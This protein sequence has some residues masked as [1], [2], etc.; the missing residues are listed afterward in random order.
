MSAHMSRNCDKQPLCTHHPPTAAD[1]N[2]RSR[3]NNSSSKSSKKGKQAIAT[4]SFIS[5]AV[6]EEVQAPMHHIN[7]RFLS[8]MSILCWEPV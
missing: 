4:R 6:V 5:K 3:S 8:C 7:G 1:V 2:G